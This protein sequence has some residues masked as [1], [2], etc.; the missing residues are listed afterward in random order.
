L[1]LP[2]R[3]TDRN[4]RDLTP[5]A[6]SRPRLSNAGGLARLTSEL[7]AMFSL[8]LHLRHKLQA[9]M[10]LVID[11]KPLVEWTE[12]RA[13]GFQRRVNRPISTSSAASGSISDSPRPRLAKLDHQPHRSVPVPV[14]EG[15]RLVL[16]LAV[17]VDEFSAPLGLR[18]GRS[19]MVAELPTLAR[20]DDRRATSG[21]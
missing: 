9:L 2:A 11:P 10:G 18:R 20:D 6:S 19:G 17:R 14:G 15:V 3:V 16:R 4:T 5:V 13:A 1:T 21:S 7:R 12:G 8:A